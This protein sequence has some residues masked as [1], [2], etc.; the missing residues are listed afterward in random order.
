MND[1][2]SGPLLVELFL[3]GCRISGVTDKV[4]NRRRLVDLLNGQETMLEL[5]EA[6][7]TYAGEREPR[8]YNLLAIEKRSI[9]VAIP[10]ETQQQNRQRAMLTSMVGRAQT[11]QVPAAILIPPMTIE[12]MVHVPPGSGRIRPEPEKFTHFFPLTVARISTGD[13]FFQEAPVALVNRDLI[14]GMSI[15][16]DSM[17]KASSF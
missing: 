16:T 9:L 7:V 8:L 12:G 14:V 1:G 6:K 10:R 4:E 17:P 15:M 5:E 11:M 2:P 3:E 13:G